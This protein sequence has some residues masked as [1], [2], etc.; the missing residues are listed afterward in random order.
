MKLFFSFLLVFTVH[1]AT[2]TTAQASDKPQVGDEA[3]Y[4]MDFY[5]PNGQHSVSYQIQR[6][7]S[8]LLKTDE[9][10][11][12]ILDGHRSTVRMMPARLVERSMFYYY[13]HGFE[14]CVAPY[15]KLETLK[16]PAGE[17]TSCKYGPDANKST[18]WS[19]KVPFMILKS[20]T[21][22]QDGSSVVQTLVR[23]IKN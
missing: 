13:T 18:G 22:E 5:A 1:L 16:V 4:R 21:H 17:F 2:A 7:K 19:G 20:E 6:L 10:E 11:V 23:Y 3:E 8:Y 12:E 14:E 15:F 9:F